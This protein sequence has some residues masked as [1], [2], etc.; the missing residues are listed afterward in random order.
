MASLYSIFFPRHLW[1]KTE[2]FCDEQPVCIC[3]AKLT[4]IPKAHQINFTCE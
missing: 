3:L 2:E 1:P 4:K